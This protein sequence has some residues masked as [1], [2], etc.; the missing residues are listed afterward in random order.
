MGKI[1][2]NLPT[3][4]VVEKPV[5]TC[6][7]VEN[8]KYL[9]LDAENIGSMGLPI[10]LVCKIMDNKVVKITEAAE[11]QQAKD[12]LKGI[13][14]GNAMNY[15]TV[16]DE[17]IADEV[18]YTQLTL[19]VASFDVIKNSYKVEEVISE[20]VITLEENVAVEEPVIPE[21]TQEVQEE[22]SVES[23]PVVSEP[24]INI[25]T[26][27]PVEPVNI[28]EAPVIEESVVDIQEPTSIDFNETKEA[29]MKAC[30]N[31]FDALVSKFQAELNSKK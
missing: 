11:W 10:I 27:I 24:A 23:E 29:F 22:V 4:A 16:A 13:I 7:E 15:V 20:P 1:K 28:E 31:M 9:I 8:N 19:P 26:E 12:Y 2:L 25:E 30:E 17:M 6:F 5:V 3:G 18:Y 14:A 21:F